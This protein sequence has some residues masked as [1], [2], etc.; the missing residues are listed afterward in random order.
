MDGI[1]N[2]SGD[3]TA[4]I[5]IGG[6]RY[7]LRPQ[8]L[9]EYA[10]RER[11]ILSLKPNPIEVAAKSPPEVRDQLLE[12]AWSEATRPQIVTMDEESRFDASMHGI[13]WRFWRAVRRDHPEVAGVQDALDLI[14]TL[15][16]D[17]FGILLDALS[18]A[19]EKDI[20]GNSDGRKAGPQQPTSDADT[21]EFRGHKSTE[22]SASVTAGDSVTSTT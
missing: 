2:L 8:V 15:G 14:E 21:S 19:E 3:R 12:R 17:R 16:N 4:H 1:S 10:E 7:T 6:K 18:E 9:A 22:D 20:L 13:A 5:T 11:Y